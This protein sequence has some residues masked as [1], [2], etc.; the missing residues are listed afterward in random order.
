MQ[1]K[2]VKFSLWNLADLMSGQIG[3]TE[4]DEK[5]LAELYAKK[6]SYKDKGKELGKTDSNKIAALEKKTANNE[7]NSTA[8]KVVR[9]KWMNLELGR[10]P[11]SIGHLPMIRKGVL[12][13]QAG[14]D[15]VAE[16]YPEFGFLVSEDE[17]I[18]N[19][20]LYGIADVV[21]RNISLPSLNYSGNVVID[22]KNLETLDGL[23]EKQNTR[24][25]IDPKYWAQ[26]QGYGSLYD[27]ELLVIAYVLTDLPPEMMEEGINKIAWRYGGHNEALGNEAY[28]SEVEQFIKNNTYSD[29]PAEKRVVLK[30]FKRDDDFLKSVQNRIDKYARPYYQELTD[31]WSKGR[32]ELIDLI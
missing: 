5:T 10:R 29:I 27:A 13:E 26:L 7:L 21:C 19:D 6:Q 32:L 18:F 16:V 20:W 4:K 8:K 14:I 11:K 31:T 17:P 9:Q 24:D 3:L 2:K 25:K 28:E 12:N 1:S 23:L 15:L 30:I 22:I